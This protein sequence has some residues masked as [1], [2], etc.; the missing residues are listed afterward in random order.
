MDEM[1]EIINMVINT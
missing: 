1:V